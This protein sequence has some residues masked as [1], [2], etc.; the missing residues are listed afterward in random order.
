MEPNDGNS[1]RF[2][3]RQKPVSSP[4]QNSAV[5]REPTSDLPTKMSGS[6]SKAVSSASQ[7]NDAKADT[8][9]ARLSW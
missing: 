2:E 1:N 3:A 6:E 9:I 4:C 5:Q 8:S 7:L